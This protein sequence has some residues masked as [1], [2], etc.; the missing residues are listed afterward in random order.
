MEEILGGGKI[1]AA[2]AAVV[3]P[4]I[5]TLDGSNEDEGYD[6]Y[7]HSKCEDGSSSSGRA[8]D[9]MATATKRMSSPERAPS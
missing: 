3:A 5:V 4:C 8:M 6:P 9:V 2:A 7:L 1:A